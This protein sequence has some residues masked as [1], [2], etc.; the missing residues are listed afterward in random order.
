MK[1]LSITICLLVLLFSSSVIIAE[2]LD[3][4]EIHQVTFDT[5]VVQFVSN[6][7]Y[8]AEIWAQTTECYKCKSLFVS[9]LLSME[10]VEL[11]V[12]TRYPMLFQV[13]EKY[14]TTSN[15]SVSFRYHFGENGKYNVS[16]EI[17]EKYQFIFVVDV[18]KKP[19]FSATPIFVAIG[20]YAGLIC[21]YIA[22]KQASRHKCVNKVC[23]CCGSDVLNNNATVSLEHL[24]QEQTSQAEQ[25]SANSGK[26]PRTKRLRS[27]DTFRGLSLVIMIFVNYGGGRY[28]YFEHSIW[29]GLTVADLVFP[30]F[31]FIMGTSITLSQH[32][33]RSKGITKLQIFK[34]I[35][36]RTIILFLLGLFLNTAGGHNDLHFI[37]IPGVLQRFSISYFVV[38][39]LELMF[40]K[41]T[42]KVSEGN[43]YSYVADV[44]DY[45][46]EWLVIIALLVT[47]TCLTFLLPVSGCPTGYLG[48]GGDMIYGKNSSYSLCTGGA[49]GYIDKWFFG[50]DHIYQYPTCQAVYGTGAYDPEGML[51]SITSIFMTFLGLQAGKIIFHFPGNGQ[52]LSRLVIWGILTGAIGT[53]LCKASKDDGWIPVNKNLWSL[54]YVLVLAS[55]AF[56]LLAFFYYIIDVKPWYSGNPFYYAGMNSILLYV[57]HEV[58]FGYFPLSWAPYKGTHAEYLAMNLIGTSIWVLVAYHCYTIKFFLK[59]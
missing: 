41:A 32:S 25:S 54:T 29:N 50:E 10:H 13:K 53:I 26:K 43:W 8:D 19:D 5:A 16:V 7:V 23:C 44:F 20:I 11:L 36:R 1:K 4:L 38:A 48:P 9:D 12:D 14:N 30:W 33:L 42:R 52:R 27:L 15:T 2:P 34:K 59:I 57:S 46:A 55:M 18:L 28:W 47:H 31:V 40:A 58:F 21:L 45:W 24:K 49:A 17:D 6:L 35:I 3:I 51:G 56:I 39:I 37:R 22:L